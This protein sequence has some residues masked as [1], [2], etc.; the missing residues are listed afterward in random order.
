MDAQ[1]QDR[2]HRIGQTRE[3]HIY[4]LVCSSTIEEN[5]LTKAQQ[6]KH[7]DYLVM[8][9]GQF[10]ENSLFSSKG[11]RDVLEGSD[12]GAVSSASTPK[13]EA[14]GNAPTEVRRADF[15]AAI[16]AMEDEE[17]VSA[18]RGVK[19]ELAQDQEEFDD[20]KPIVINVDE[21]DTGAIPSS[22]A[23]TVA[24]KQDP[25]LN[26]L[27]ETLNEER[28]VEAEFA[29]W[30]ATVGGDFSSLEQA[31]KPVERYALRFREEVEHFQ[32]LFA[33][34][35]QQ[36]LHSVALEAEELDQAWDVGEIEREKE[37][38]EQRAL[39]EGELLAAN[40]T[41]AEKDVHKRWY[42][43]QRRKQS[44]QRRMRKMT[45]D[46]W[47]YT[48]DEITR[49]PYWYNEDTGEACYGRPKVIVDKEIF[50]AAVKNK[51]NSAPLHVIVTILS[52]LDPYP[53]RMNAKLTCS[54]WCEAGSDTRLFKRVLPVET[55][56]R[57][58]LLQGK[59]TRLDENTFVDLEQALA[60]SQPGDVILLGA[61]HYWGDN[62]DIRHPIMLRGDTGESSRCIIELS[63][64]IT[65]DL[66][67]SK[68]PRG[69][70]VI[71][72]ISVQRLQRRQT[73]ETKMS[74][75]INII[76]SQLWAS[77][78]FV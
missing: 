61:G 54:L 9:E 14:T 20:S 78:Y 8:T 17:D 11:L 18:M 66:R 10:S 21:D 51:F 29:S 49:V 13:S 63:G 1:A 52:Y 64:T 7:L 30:Q 26:Q 2:A 56:A 50:A 65:V 32:S 74:G 41:R 77:A 75:Y 15:E 43:K 19:S 24:I 33:L 35:E 58:A 16:A 62:L 55:G 48:I 40:L 28:D 71:S 22:S 59:L 3:V 70:V 68:Q 46:A 25:Q 38:E 45:G 39:A 34:T 23:G 44:Q 57:D 47:V 37:L 72:G 76:G 67:A 36:R 5:I 69:A 42:R 12:G 31:L 53:D 4:R 73:R 6:K 27:N 60:Q